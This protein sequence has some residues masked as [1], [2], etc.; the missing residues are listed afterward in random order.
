MNKHP[1]TGYLTE[2]EYD[3]M[4]SLPYGGAEYYKKLAQKR[5]RD[6]KKIRKPANANT[7]K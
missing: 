6:A 2:Q 4:K 5:E 1:V 7:K 3:A